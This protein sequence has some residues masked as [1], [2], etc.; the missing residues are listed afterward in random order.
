MEAA[1]AGSGP[2]AGAR[3]R[4]GAAVLVG[5]PDGA[6]ASACRVPLALVGTTVLTV[7]GAAGIKRASLVTTST[8][9]REGA[10]AAGAPSSDA[11]GE[12]VLD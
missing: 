2:G 8:S 10:G 9:A 6:D 1:A 5:A 7:P 3:V 4:A 11:S 12:E